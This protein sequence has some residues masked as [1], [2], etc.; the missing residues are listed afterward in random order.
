MR[1]L[2]F[3]LYKKRLNTLYNNVFIFMFDT[4]VYVSAV[5]RFS[6]NA[7]ILHASDLFLVIKV[8]IGWQVLQT[9]I[10]LKFCGDT[11]YVFLLYAI[12]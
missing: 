2:D 3:Q 4:T 12:Q 1:K 9:C 6:L 11:L 7:S 10:Y 8:N 5:N